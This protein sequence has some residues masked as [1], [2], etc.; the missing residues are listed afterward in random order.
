MKPIFDCNCDCRLETINA[1]ECADLTSTQPGVPGRGPRCQRFGR[2][3]PVASCVR[4]VPREG[5]RRRAVARKRLGEKQHLWSAL[6]CQRFV[7]STF[8]SGCAWECVDG[9]RRRPPRAKAVTGQR[10]QK[11]ACTPRVVRIATCGDYGS[12]ALPSNSLCD[13]NRLL[14]RQS[15]IAIGN[16]VT[17]LLEAVVSFA[18]VSVM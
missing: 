18:A 8:A 11:V 15:A 9:T 17:A 13:L 6:I 4:E 7:G 10:T 12:S 16:G 2:M 5:E 1:L 14:N 3:R